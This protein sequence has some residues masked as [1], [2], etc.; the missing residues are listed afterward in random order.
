[1]NSYQSCKNCWE[2]QNELLESGDASQVICHCLD[3]LT[4]EEIVDEVTAHALDEIEEAFP[5][6]GGQLEIADDGAQFKIEQNDNNS[7]QVEEDFGGTSRCEIEEVSSISLPCTTPK[8]T[9]IANKNNH[10]KAPSKKRKATESPELAT[11]NVEPKLKKRLFHES[12]PAD[13]EFSKW[14]R[15]MNFPNEIMKW[16]NVPLNTIYHVLSIEITGSNGDPYIHPYIAT[17]KS[18][19]GN[20]FKVWIRKRIYDRLKNYDMEKKCVYIRS[21]GLKPCRGDPSK[22]Y[23]D[24]SIIVK[25]Q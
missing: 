15:S 20:I 17:M 24:F 16:R 23:F 4:E 21:Y 7:S 11:S 5:S 14:E 2:R 25:E 10:L 3:G 22:Q 12:F 8:N 6:G 1:M 9:V 19:S 13:K 18:K